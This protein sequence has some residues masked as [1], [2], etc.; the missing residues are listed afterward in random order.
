MQNLY[1]LGKPSIDPV[2]GKKKNRALGFEDFF[3]L[4]RL[5]THQVLCVVK[6]LETREIYWITLS[7]IGIEITGQAVLLV[8]FVYFRIFLLPNLSL[9][10]ISICHIDVNIYVY[11]ACICVP[12]CPV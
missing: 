12:A 7:E 4:S 3:D 2:T 5:K 8:G 10:F 6:S 1:L 9:P 11:H